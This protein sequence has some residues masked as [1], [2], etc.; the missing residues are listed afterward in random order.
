MLIQ[1]VK[2]CNLVSMFW[3]LGIEKPLN[4]CLLNSFLN[5]SVFLFLFFF[6]PTLEMRGNPISERLSNVSIPCLGSGREDTR[7]QI[8]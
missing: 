1:S 4:Q 3:K 5:G 7:T 8:F 2:I 6:L